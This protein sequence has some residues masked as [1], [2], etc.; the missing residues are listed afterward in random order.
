VTA[1]LTE[2][3][4]HRRA[5]AAF[6]AVL[7]NVKAGQLDDPTPCANWTVRD[8]I[9]HVLAGNE[10]TAGSAPD[11][12]P[13]L[14]GMIAANAASALAAQAV[15]EAPDGITRTFDVPFGT[16][17]GA[18]FIQLR[19]IDALTHAW[20]LAM[21]TAQP[22][23]LDPELAEAMLAASRQLIRPDLRGAGRPFAGEQAC[24][25]GQPPAACLA[26]FLGRRV[27]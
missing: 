24:D 27:S 7:A 16:I 22:T 8:L 5:Q 18:L 13:D 6:A 17:P 9:G 15:F 3:E 26:A 4:A 14:D 10:R 1:T 20:D 23:D 19:T 25:P 12:S 2:V 21:A 11:S